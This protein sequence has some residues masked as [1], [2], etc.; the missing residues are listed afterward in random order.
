[1]VLVF[2]YYVLHVCTC[3]TR[4]TCSILKRRRKRKQ[5]RHSIIIINFVNWGHKIYR[6]KIKKISLKLHVQ[7]PLLGCCTGTFQI[8]SF[9]FILISFCSFFGVACCTLHRD[10]TCNLFQR[11]PFTFT[12]PFSSSPKPLSPGSNRYILK[13]GAAGSV[14]PV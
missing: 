13:L 12:K 1:M 10:R 5:F 7:V 14:L 8:P 2:S 6:Y 4:I 9:L 11:S 3:S